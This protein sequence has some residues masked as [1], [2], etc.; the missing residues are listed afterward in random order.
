M[1]AQA[2]INDFILDLEE[3]TVQDAKSSTKEYYDKCKDAS[4]HLDLRSNRRGRSLIFVTTTN[5]VGWQKDVKNFYVCCKSLNI[6]TEIVYDPDA[7]EVDHKLQDF[8]TSEE[9]YNIDCCFVLFM[10]HGLERSK[11]FILKLRKDF[12]ISTQN[13]NF[14]SERK[15]QN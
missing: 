6:T 12:L 15:F 9:N 4:Y 3:L 10:G 5:R 14:T 11:M 8:V 1:A 7:N 13:V 2:E